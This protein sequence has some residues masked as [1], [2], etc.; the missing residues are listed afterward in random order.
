MT[1]APSQNGVNSALTVD[2]WQVMHLPR[3]ARDPFVAWL[4]RVAPAEV[5][6]NAFHLA[7]H[8]GCVEITYYLT[9]SRGRRYM[10]GDCPAQATWQDWDCEPPPM[11]SLMMA[12]QLK[13]RTWTP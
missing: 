6:D 1:P 7:L 12:A 11:G 2:A 4:H 13:P 10:E 5:A 8:Q 9:D 3:H